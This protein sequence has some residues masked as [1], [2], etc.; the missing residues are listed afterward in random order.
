MIKNIPKKY[1]IIVV[2]AIIVAGIIFAIFKLIGSP[3]QN[4]T[5][6][7][8]RQA[9]EL[10]A[11]KIMFDIATYYS[12]QNNVTEFSKNASSTEQIQTEISSLKNQY[13]GDYDYKIYEASEKGMAVKTVEKTSNAYYCIDSMTRTPVEIK[14]DQF[15][16]NSDCTGEAL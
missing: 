2:S 4:A 12:D 9:S 10:L 7:S 11:V 8:R 6:V 14:S 1:L 15:S 3:S 5:T 16:V 13:G